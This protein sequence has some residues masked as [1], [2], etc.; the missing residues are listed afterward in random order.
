MFID[1]AKVNVMAGKGGDGCN[2]FYRDLYTRYGIPDGGEGGKGGDV[3]LKADEN[4]ATLLDFQYRRHFKAESGAHGSGKNQTGK[5]GKDCRIL[6]PCGTLVY[7][8]DKKYLLK[9]LKTAGE[10]IIICHGGKGGFGNKRASSARK[11]LPGEEK[12]INLELKLIADVGIIG[13]PNAGKSSLINCLCDT[14][15]KVAAYEFTTKEPILGVVKASRDKRIVI[16]DIPGLIDGAH[17]GRGLGHK[18]LKH[19]ERTKIL[20][21]LIDVSD[22]GKASPAVKYKK[23]IKE[24][25]LYSKELIKKPQI[26]VA[27]K[28]DLPAAKLN[29]KILKEQLNCDVIAV[30][31]A[32][33]EG[34]D[35][36]VKRIMKSL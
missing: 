23:L 26:V 8:K 28:M 25:E 6:V 21:H 17:N 13:Y 34:L 3:I 7:D 27:N 35:V 4:I 10:Q 5:S 18:F 36:L 32:T 20:I 11:G 2:S 30:S 33:Q 16:A 15:S 9:D 12:L 1:Q 22:E 24:L 29:L 19:I 14:K 31:C